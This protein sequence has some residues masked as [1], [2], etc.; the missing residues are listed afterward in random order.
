MLLA[1]CLTKDKSR[2]V[3]TTKVE[4]SICCLVKSLVILSETKNLLD[5]SASFE[6]I[7]HCVQND[8]GSYNGH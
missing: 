5:Y 7:L 6:R 2:L 3:P 1:V 8:R 4:L